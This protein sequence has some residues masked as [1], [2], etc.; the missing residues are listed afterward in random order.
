MSHHKK[1][2]KNQHQAI[3]HQKEQTLAMR[4]A[5]CRKLNEQIKKMRQHHTIKISDHAIVRFLERTCIINF[6]WIKEQLISADVL[7]YYHTLGDGEYPTGI[8]NV[9]VIIKDAVIV[10][11]I[12]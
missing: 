12:V 11:V 1:Q 3:L 5:E 4:E 8:G 2:E 10:T 9:R 7:K 6:E